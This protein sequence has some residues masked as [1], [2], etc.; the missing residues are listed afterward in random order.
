MFIRIPDRTR[1]EGLKRI[2]NSSTS[3]P[4]WLIVLERIKNGPAIEPETVSEECA[5]RLRSQ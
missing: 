1:L 5:Y 4:W 2:M 3:R